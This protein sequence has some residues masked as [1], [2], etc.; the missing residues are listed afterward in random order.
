M[1]DDILR[2][3]AREVIQ[4]GNLSRH[5]L[6]RVRAG[7]SVAAPC[8]VCGAPV[9]QLEVGFEVEFTRDGGFSA[10]RRH[11]HIRCFTAFEFE[12]DRLGLAGRTTSTRD[13]P[14]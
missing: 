3:K 5:C 10:T 7:P 14:L 11:F 1:S 13:Q 12:L 8:M 2:E 4:A 9:Q 6:E